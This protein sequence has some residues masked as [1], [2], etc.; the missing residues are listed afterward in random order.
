[1]NT[2]LL[3]AQNICRVLYEHF[4][5]YQVYPA[6]TGG[7]LYKDGLRKDIDIVLFQPAC[8][9]EL[10]GNKP[11]V[12]QSV[13]AILK[14]GRAVSTCILL[15]LFKLGFTNVRDFNAVI[16]CTYKGQNIDLILPQAG[17]GTYP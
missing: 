8:M 12:T 2:N 6:L 14:E 5:K 9:G 7:T 11:L 17:E 10:D 4:S 15:E 1:M 16:K 3:I 13:P